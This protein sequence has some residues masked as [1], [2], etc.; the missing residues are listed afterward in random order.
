MP[1][2]ATKTTPKISVKIW[3]PILEK[4]DVKLDAAC[5]RRDAYLGKL[6]ETELPYLD[7]E[8]SVQNSQASYDFVA[9]KLDLLDR[10]LVSLALPT[11]LTARLN[12]ICSRKRIVRDAFFNRLFLLLAAAPKTID[13]LLFAYYD[14]NWRSDVWSE[15]KHDGPFIQNGFDP[16]LAEIDPFWAIREGIRL[17]NVGNEGTDEIDPVTGATRKVTRLA[18]QISPEDSLYSRIFTMKIGEHDLYGLSCSL[19]DWAVPGHEAENSLRRSLD[20]MMEEIK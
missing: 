9:S 19:P 3:R 17:G 13:I 14:G 4:L 1:P 6:L 15:W 5:L 10:K 12:D 18:G 16:L 2:K 11:D 7:S 8:V 20:E